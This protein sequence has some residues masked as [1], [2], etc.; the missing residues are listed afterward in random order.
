MG[1]PTSFD[2]S[3]K[4]ALVTGAS[5]GLGRHFAITLARA[6]AK[7]AAA[8]RRIESLGE[9][10]RE[11]EA[12]DGRAIPVE[13]DVTDPKS[14][15]ACVT[16]SE[17]ELGPI[18]ILINNAGI[19]V[20]KGLLETSEED[21]HA[22]IE[23]NLSGVWRLARETADHMIRLGHG[24]SIINIASILGETGAKGVASYCASKA[25]VINLTR[26]LAAELSRHSI[27]VNAIAPGYFETD[28]NRAFLQSDAGQKLRHKVLQRRFGDPRELDGPLL[29]LASEGSKYMTGSVL[30]V[31]GGLTAAL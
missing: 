17:T 6:G 11:I 1:S 24:G 10:A 26:A 21:W 9:V 19:A 25:G 4:T 31:D 2:L 12:L 3:G 5:G 20:D 18:S 27:R 28:M 22:V 23:T 30:T 13:L 14:V 15:S 8:G 16:A 7:I 29:L